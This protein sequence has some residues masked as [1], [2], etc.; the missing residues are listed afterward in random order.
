MKRLLLL[1]TLVTPIGCAASRWTDPL[2]LS[3]EQTI[4]SREMWQ[5]TTG[6]GDFK[7]GH[8]PNFYQ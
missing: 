8:S 2:R 5:R 4:E 7:D 3:Y 6:H 1:L